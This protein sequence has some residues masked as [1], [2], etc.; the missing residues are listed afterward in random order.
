MKNILPKNVTH[1]I[2]FT[3]IVSFVHRVYIIK[4]KDDNDDYNDDD[5]D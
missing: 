1:N 4:K 2:I 5:D 3:L